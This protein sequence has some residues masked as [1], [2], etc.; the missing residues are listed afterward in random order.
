VNCEAAQTLISAELDK[1]G[2]AADLALLHAHLRECPACRT[3]ADAWSSQ[4]A[5]LQ[6][7][8]ASRRRAA[9]GNA[10][11]AIAKL[12]TLS[13]H[14]QRRRSWL[15]LLAAA[16]A[17]FLLATLL[18]R[19][20]Q[21]RNAVQPPEFDAQSGPTP[22]SRE[23]DML[24][25]AVANKTIEVQLPD[26]NDWQ[27]AGPGAVI[28]TGAHVRTGPAVRCELHTADGSEIRLNGETELAYL[29]SRHMQLTRGQ[30]LA[31]VAK[32][33]VAFQVGVPDATVTALG[34]EFDLH[35]KPAETVLTVLQ[36]VTKVEGKGPEAV[37][38][39]GQAAVIVDGKV[40]ALQTIPNLV[41][42]TEWTHELLMLKGRD[43]QEL[44][45][46]VNDI[47][48]T[49]GQTK[50]DQIS[51]QDIR[52]LGDH[53]VLPLIRYIQSDRSQTA[54]NAVKRHLA[55]QI[56]ADLAQP[57]AIPYL[58]ELLSDKNGDIR[59]L[60]ARALKRLTQNTFQCEP[61]AWRQR[62]WTDTR[63]QW[64]AWWQ[65]NKDRYPSVP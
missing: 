18:F 5:D 6:R 56:V 32:A 7:A 29:S 10:E 33:A 59:A 64:Q 9:A 4:D 16:A 53:C 46:R 40:T 2:T 26:R 37:V 35:C 17:G 60:A 20:W 52:S 21:D 14:S 41:K 61:E 23:R 42:A 28:P 15:P 51:Q 54:D 30:I 44:A 43:N 27:A 19:P 34:T 65:A 25:L 55:A 31:Q 22:R 50:M 48:A 45:K 47:L 49:I 3:T 11:R 36:G 39:K 13:A 38:G 24:T 62:S 12:Q 63:Q 58:I 57:W 8:F 1:A